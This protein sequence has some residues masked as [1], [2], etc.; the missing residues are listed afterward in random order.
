MPVVGPTRQRSATFSRGFWPA[1]GR[2][3]HLLRSSYKKANVLPKN[4]NKKGR[5]LDILS[6]R[7]SFFT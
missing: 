6:K 1:E 5:D 7:Y 2:N 3:E 4:K